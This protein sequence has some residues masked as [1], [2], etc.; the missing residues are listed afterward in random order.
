[1]IAEEEESEKESTP[2]SFCDVKSKTIDN[3]FKKTTSRASLK[4]NASSTDSST[5]KRI[6][7]KDENTNRNKIQIKMKNL[8][9]HQRNNLLNIQKSY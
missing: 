8:Q 5:V 2:T 4:R 3:S 6:A 9:N 1:M 7:K